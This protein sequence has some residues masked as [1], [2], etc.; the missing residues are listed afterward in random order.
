MFNFKKQFAI[1]LV[2]LAPFALGDEYTCD[3]FANIYD[4]GEDLCNTMFGD[5]FEYT[6]DEDNA[7]SMWWFEAG[8]PNDQITT[9]LNNT[10]PKTCN[11]SY[12]HKDKPSAEGSDFTECHPWKDSAC[13]TEAT[14][15]TAEALNKAYGAGYEWD[16]CGKLSQACERFF[17]Q[18]ACLYE[19]DP[20]IGNYRKCSD[21]QVAAASDDDA[22][23]Y[24][25][26]EMNKMP[27]KASYCNAWYT[28]CYEDK[29]C[30]GA[31]GDF[32]TC[33]EM[34]SPEEAKDKPLMP[35]WAVGL[36][37]VLALLF[38]VGG[39]LFVHT[40]RREIKGDPLFKP[41]TQSN[42]IS[43]EGSEPGL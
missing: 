27:I 37:V 31:D 30:G 6:T 32:F 40:I 23:A 19:C 3:T 25:T 33:A 12:F 34:Y 24:N 39:C 13:C 36:I 43:K 28:A 9:A 21:A 4:D 16:R 7:F 41:L 35:G 15:T 8:N 10:V 22:C 20:N 42:P 17:V 14:V 38:C 26:W 11:V 1:A 2:A 5:A 18:E 29:F